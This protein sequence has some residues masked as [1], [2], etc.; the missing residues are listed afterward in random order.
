MVFKE[1]PLKGVQK[2]L[3]V[4]CHERF[5]DVAIAGKRH[6]ELVKMLDGEKD[7]Q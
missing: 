3:R 7:F 6:D 4:V 5:G 1:G 2:G